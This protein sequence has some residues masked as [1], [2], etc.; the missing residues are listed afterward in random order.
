MADTERARRSLCRA[1]QW[2]PVTVAVLRGV[3]ALQG[4]SRD[5]TDLLPLRKRPDAGSALREFP[6]AGD[7]PGTAGRVVAVTVARSRRRRRA[8]N[9]IKHGDAEARS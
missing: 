4:R 8:R 7:I 5:S 1:H 3:R 9:K 6:G 2:R